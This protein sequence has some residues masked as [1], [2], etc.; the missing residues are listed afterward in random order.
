MPVI[1]SI[2]YS[3]EE[4]LQNIVSLHTGEIQADVT[5]GSGCFYKKSVARP[6][7]CF[8]LM[9]RVPGVIAADV[10]KLPLKD[11]CLRSVV[12]DPPFLIRTG[13]GSNLKSRYGCI[14]G[15]MVGLGTF[16][17]LALHELHRVLIPKGWL[18]FKCQDLVSG[19]KNHFIHCHIWE[20]ARGLGFEAIDLFILE[21]TRR[22]ADPQGRAQKHARKFHSYFRVF[23]KKP[24]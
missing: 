9:P 24:Q 11:C 5:F 23:K 14:E 15:G 22:Q 12:F 13:H 6:K 19:G 7:F 17:A 16:Y 3:Q 4:I 10:C 21:A 20:H 8:D 2:S 18:I 1:K